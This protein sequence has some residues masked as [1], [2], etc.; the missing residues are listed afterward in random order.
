MMTLQRQNVM[1]VKVS[2]AGG[3]LDDGA[4]ILAKACQ[5]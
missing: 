4:K 2:S 1:I 3:S 5:D